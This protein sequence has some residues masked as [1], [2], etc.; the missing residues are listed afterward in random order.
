MTHPNNY[1]FAEEIAEKGLEAIP[2][3]MRVLINNAMQVERSRY[4][5]AEQYERTKDR[6]GHANGFKPKTIQT[7]IGNITFAVPQVREGGFYPSALE[8]GLRSERALTITLAEMYVQGV[9]TRKVK[10]I[11]EQLCGIE[12]SATQVSR[13]TA[14]LDEVLQEWRERP[15]G[16][17]SYLFV[18][19]RYE[20]IR[21]AGQVRDAA[22]LVAS[23][24]T[25][26]GER[27]ILG[28]SVSLSEHET[29]WKAFLKS[30]KERGLHGIKLIISDDH[31][32][33]GAARRAVFGGIPWQRCQFHLQQ[34]AGA[35]LPRQSMRL[36]VA[37][38]IRAIFNAPD[39]KTAEEL[40]QS[41]IQKYAI[42][43][44][45]LSSWLE[46]NLFEGF[47][48]FDFPLEHRRTIRTTNS[49]E[50]INKEIRRR[51]RVV[52]VFPNQASCLRLVS[53]LLMETCEE[54]QIGKHFCTGKFMNS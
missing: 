17:I 3:M 37:A 48:V 24:I 5:Q 49:L 14:Q 23:G 35:Y 13:A 6:K 19:A 46:N 10:T 21:E 51:T 4:L 38:D 39:R 27:Q 53:A 16:E 33:L 54:W 41:A 26:E 11:T 28:V 31:E 22:V 32:G 12:V 20:K 8:K 9:S 34:N 47:L 30:L 1:T 25:P 15:L 44:P 42:S 43:A 40:L 2:E 52:G 36:E 29:H 45:R 50:R 7:R 18:D